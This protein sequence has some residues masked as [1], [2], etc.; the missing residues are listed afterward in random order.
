MRPSEYRG[1]PLDWKELSHATF[2]DSLFS[3]YSWGLTRMQ[4]EDQSLMYRGWPA[5]EAPYFFLV[6]LA[7]ISYVDSLTNGFCASVQFEQV[8]G[9]YK[10][11]F[12]KETNVVATAFCSCVHVAW[13]TA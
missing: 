12:T 7:G 4:F 8:K 9:K 3:E 6:H 1:V 13:Y 2:P 11:S 5:P 10:V